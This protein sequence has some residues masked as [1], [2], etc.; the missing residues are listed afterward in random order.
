MNLQDL[1]KE[2]LNLESDLTALDSNYQLQI[3]ENDTLVAT[4]EERVKEV[5]NLKS[6]VWSAKQKLTKSEEENKAMIKNF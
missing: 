4:L 6:R 3:S 2:K 1:D 5:D